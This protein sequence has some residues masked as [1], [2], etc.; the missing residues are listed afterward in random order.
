MRPSILLYDWDNTLVDGRAAIAAA[1]DPL[2]GE[3]AAAVVDG[4]AAIAPPLNAVFSVFAMPHWT[5][6]D[7]RAR[8]RASLA[9]SFPAMFGDRWTEARDIFYATLTEHHLVHVRP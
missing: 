7:T 9:E 3:Q 2:V 1:L 5:A 6:D 4:G 8:A